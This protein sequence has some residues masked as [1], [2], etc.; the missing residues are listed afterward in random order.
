MSRRLC[1]ADSKRKRIKRKAD[2]D[3]APAKKVCSPQQSVLGT[4]SE[5]SQGERGGLAF[6]CLPLAVVADL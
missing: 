1:C 2:A 6:D 5:C 4:C 3:E